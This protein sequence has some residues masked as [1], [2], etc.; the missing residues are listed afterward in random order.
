MLLAVPPRI[1]GENPILAEHASTDTMIATS[2]PP[3]AC[4]ESA[5]HSVS[6]PALTVTWRG[7]LL[8]HHADHLRPS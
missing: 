5:N 4:S 3:D 6:V 2:T 1:R 8:F 7:W